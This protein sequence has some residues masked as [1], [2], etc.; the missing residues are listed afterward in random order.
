MNRARNIIKPKIGQHCGFVKDTG[1]RN[2]I[3]MLR[4]ILENT[5]QM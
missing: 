2:D 4:M 5:I 1:I 3:L